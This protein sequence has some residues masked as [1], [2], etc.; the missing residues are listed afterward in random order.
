MSAHTTVFG[1]A[2]VIGDI[3]AGLSGSDPATVTVIAGPAGIGRST[4]LAEVAHG[5]RDHGLVT[6]GF[7]LT[8]HDRDIPFYLVSRLAGALSRLSAENRGS[9]RVTGATAE[10][11]EPAQI[12]AELAAMMLARPGL[13]VLIDDAHLLDPASRAVLEQ[14]VA[15]LG[16]ATVQWICTVRSATGPGRTVEPVVQRL[17][18]DRLARIV[19]L[20]P[21]TRS[22]IDDLIA[23]L[24]RARPHATLSDRLVRLSRGVPAAVRAAIDGCLRAGSLHVVDGYGYLLHPSRPLLLADGHPIA[25]RFRE[26]PADTRTVAKAAAVLNPLRERLP[27]LIADASGLGPAAVAEA[28]R[29][30]TDEGILSTTHDGAQRFAVPLW[31]EV[32]DQALGPYERRELARTAVEAIWSGT[33]PPRDSHYLSEQLVRCDGFGRPGRASAELFRLGSKAIRRDTWAA[34]RWLA[35]AAEL[36][37]DSRQRWLALGAHAAAAVSIGDFAAAAHSSELLMRLDEN[38]IP[39]SEA[40]EIQLIHLNALWGLGDIAAVRR[41]ADGEQFLGQRHAHRAICRT[42]ALCHLG[43]WNEAYRLLDEGRQC[44]TADE[45]SAEYGEIVLAAAGALTGRPR[46]L[47]ELLD[48]A[49]ERRPLARGHTLLVRLALRILLTIGDTDQAE[50][51][52]A[53]E[54]LPADQ[55]VNLDRTLLAWE[56]GRW[57]E[58]LHHARMTGAGRQS[59]NKPGPEVLHHGVAAILLGRGRLSA[60]REALTAARSRPP[61]LMHIL[62][63]MD[64]AIARILGDDKLALRYVQDGLAYA[65]EH[66]LVPGTEDL[67]LHDA[68][69]A[70]A[71]GD[72]DEARWAMLNVVRTA[73]LQQ[74]DRSRLLALL[75]R[76]A[77]DDDHEAATE[78][79]VVARRLAQ[80]RTLSRTLS[81]VVEAGHGDPGLLSE[82]YDLLGGMNALFYRYRL[83]RQMRSHDVLV[84][85]RGATVAENDRLLATLI[86]DGASNRELATVLLTS[87]KSIE[88]MLARLFA[89]TGY[90]SRVDLVTAVLTGDYPAS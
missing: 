56:R 8:R 51:L 69:L 19:P 79:V 21:L 30:L 77:V 26:L 11:G 18:A 16:R 87:T 4:V 63:V 36:A 3:L 9:V 57:D 67:W 47:P 75:T 24:I 31:A 89:R 1:R 72:A 55:L 34:A 83:R 78:A 6:I 73:E 64:A 71:R 43:R 80:P 48:Q 5:A 46:L 7:E 66:S 86:A 76:L 50:L 13:V 68:E 90:R 29:L 52:L 44:W 65:A 20:P 22:A 84:P 37:A 40:V 59:E 10:H 38:E 15:R 62:D 28:L 85:N 61:T 81:A 88:G 2:Q 25:A 32:L 45:A 54:R 17:V 27:E 12:T 42:A 53:R 70:L 35:A 39:D 33:A 23:E 49:F 82:A 14:L 41:I 60:A 58:A 74:T